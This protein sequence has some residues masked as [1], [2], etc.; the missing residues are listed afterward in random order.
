MNKN[1]KEEQ[2]SSE[3]LDIIDE[4]KPVINETK[5][6]IDETKPVIDEAKPV[7]DDSSKTHDS[8]KTLLM[9]ELE[10][11]HKEYQFKESQYLRAMADLENYKRR[12]ARERTEV[13]KTA[14]E[15]LLL[16]LLP[17]LDSL[18]AG[19]NITEINT[20]TIN[21]IEGFRMSYF[22][23]KRI[24]KLH[25]LSEINPLG[26]NFNPNLHECVAHMASD[27]EAEGDVMQVTRV[28]YLLGSKLLRPATVIVSSG[29]AG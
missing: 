23:L 11:S 27:Q 17:V 3:N 16:D 12:V 19:L 14:T 10:K 21:V 25:G 28:G 2:T 8:S 20:E 15:K 26:E 6:V 7:I 4:T 9:E 1:P 18:N 5:S 29:I 22:E 24:L 13:M